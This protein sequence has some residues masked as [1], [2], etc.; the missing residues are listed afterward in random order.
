MRLVFLLVLL[1]GMGIAG[2]AGYLILQQ[3]GGYDNRVAKLQK[4]I[5]SL[6]K[7]VVETKSVM[8]ATE[9]ISYGEALS[10]RHVRVVKFPAKA[11]PKGAFFSKEALLG[12][13]KDEKTAGRVAIRLIEA[14]EVIMSSKVSKFGEDA[15]VAARLEVGERAFT[16]RVDV[17]SGVSGFLRPGDIVDVIWTGTGQDGNTETRLLLDGIRLMAIDQLADEDRAKPIVARTVTVGATPSIV[18]VLAQAQATGKLQLALR[19]IDDDAK[20]GE[21][22]VI[23]QDDILQVERRA[24]RKKCYQ[25][26]RKGTEVTKRQIACSE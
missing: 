5:R 15:G 2:F 18:G 17:A 12:E 8:I 6:K 13:T 22:V 20:T 26:I 1:L 19:G 25:T 21:T 24:K 16:L 10:D 9:R 4:E 7:K 3:I 23:D 14:G 11:L